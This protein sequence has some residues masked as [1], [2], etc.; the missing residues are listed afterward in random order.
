[1]GIIE[2]EKEKILKQLL[3]WFKSKPLWVRKSIII[4]VAIALIGGFVI[5]F[6]PTIEEI[7]EKLK[8]MIRP[9]TGVYEPVKNDAN[10]DL[11][12]ESYCYRFAQIGGGFERD[13]LLIVL[14]DTIRA[15]ENGIYK[16]KVELL[17]INQRAG[18]LIK[19]GQ[20][21]YDRDLPLDQNTLVNL[22]SDCQ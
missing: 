14:T 20:T 15:D 10:A 16:V 13:A 9:T 3:E 5:W 22:Q 18:L 6:W 19:D 7:C 12:Q 21:C 4:F 1:M 17:N 11:E 8:D 2:E